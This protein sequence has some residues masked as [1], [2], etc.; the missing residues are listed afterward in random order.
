M[1]NNH[2]RDDRQTLSSHQSPINENQSI[3]F[4]FGC[5]EKK[6]FIILSNNLTLKMTKGR[7]GVYNVKEK[8]LEYQH[9]QAEPP[10]PKDGEE[11]LKRFR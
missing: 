11:F 2:Q 9:L 6:K 7:S 8:G 1:Q 4:F 3:N 5:K 10:L